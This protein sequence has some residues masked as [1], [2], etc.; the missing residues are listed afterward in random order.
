[1]DAGNAAGAPRDAQR[2][3]AVAKAAGLT[4]LD[5]LMITHWHGDHFGGLPDLVKLIPVK[6]FMDHGPNAKW[7]GIGAD[8]NGVKFAQ[9]VYPTLFGG[10]THTVVKVGDKLPLTGIDMRAIASNGE[11]IKTPLVGGG[12]SNPY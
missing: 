12:Q 7:P 3:A 5:H 8:L 4:Q 2:I 1:M 6:D 10:A 9:E 11:F